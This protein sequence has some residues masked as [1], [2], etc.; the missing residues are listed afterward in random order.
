MLKKLVIASLFATTL[1]AGLVPTA[2]GESATEP[3]SD[4]AQATLDRFEETGAE[5][6]CLR[7]RAIRSIKP[8]SDDLFLVRA[9]HNKYYLTRSKQTCRDA[10]HPT[11][12][13]T[14]D[15]NGAPR[16]CRG[17]LLTVF[18]NRPGAAGIATG[19][20]SIGTFSELREKETE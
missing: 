14:Y 7:V 13:L 10:T 3:L 1:F 17:E 15:I 6:N 4:K 16:L 2:Q 8:L 18:S 5:V 9:G 12:A 11:T 19:S 20:C